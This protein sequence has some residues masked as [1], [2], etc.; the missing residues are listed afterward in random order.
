MRIGYDFDADRSLDYRFTRTEYNYDY[1]SPFSL[2]YDKDGNPVFSGVWELPDKT[3][4]SVDPSD[5]VGYHGFYRMFIHRLQY[6]DRARQIYAH[7]GYTNRDRDGYSAPYTSPANPTP[8]S[9]N[10]WNGAGGYS[11]YPSKSY[12]FDLHKK[13]EFN[14]HTL[15]AG[16]NYRR[17]SFAQ[18]R[19][20]LDH[21]QD[22]HIDTGRSPYEYNGGKGILHAF[23]LQDKYEMND[24]TSLYLGIRYDRYTKKDGY[25]ISLKNGVVTADN[26]FGEGTYHEVSPKLAIEHRLND[27]DSVFASYGH[28][29]NPPILY[30][31][32]R[33]SST[34]NANPDLNPETTNTFEV[35]YKHADNK[36]TW[37][38]T[39]FHAKT[40][41]LVSLQTRNG[42]RA[43]Y[44]T[45]GDMAR[46]G[47]EIGAS[48]R[49]TDNWS[50]YAN[51]AFTDA[52]LNGKRY[53]YIPR[54]LVHFGLRYDAKP[55]QVLVDNTYVSERQSPD[56]DT[57]EYQSEDAF[58]LTN[59]SVNY[60]LRDG[61]VLQGAVY[62]LFDRQ[63][64]ATE[65]ARERNYSVSLQY[66]F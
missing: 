37:D 4:L 40:K 1:H 14:R 3:V 61:L 60:E 65:A 42:V 9:L 23:Y 11:F 32:Y 38:V 34:I 19:F 28:S 15:T 66:N 6:A 13:W 35:G 45:D 21:W 31:V 56:T 41:D 52:D 12:D 58:F 29:F 18:T 54:H 20:D 8:D 48:Y 16:Y 36:L 55:W 43:Y 57:G 2:V 46:R 59:L 33:K 50:A 22:I 25:N 44:N 5:F 63:F 49:F 24:A 51:Y 7:F 10:T 26:R 64:Y 17:E 53:Y 27:T 30:Q 39:L 47:A 62:N